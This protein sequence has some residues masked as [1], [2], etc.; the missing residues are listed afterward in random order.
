M[1]QGRA[2]RCLNHVDTHETSIAQ[3]GLEQHG[4][5]A[6]SRVMVVNALALA[7]AFAVI[8]AAAGSANWDPAIFAAV[9]ALTIVSD[10]TSVQTGSEELKVSGSFL[11]LMLAAVLL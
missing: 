9:A 10:L 2:Q 6:G 8:I 5:E 3:R 7:S 11:G 1:C 4:R